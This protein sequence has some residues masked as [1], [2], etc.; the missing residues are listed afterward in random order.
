MVI[1]LIVKFIFRNRTTRVWD[2]FRSIIE[3][4]FIVDL[5]MDYHDIGGRFYFHS[6]QPLL[7]KAPDKEV[8]KQQLVYVVYL[9]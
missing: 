7:P 6:L 5:V 3:V 4:G 2:A 9:C 1:F 8:S